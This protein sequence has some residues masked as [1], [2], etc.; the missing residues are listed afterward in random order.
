MVKKLI[1]SGCSFT[2]PDFI[3]DHH[4][5]LDTSW[6]KWPEILG[7]K[8]GMEVINLGRCGAG[9]EYIHASLMDKIST[10]DKSEIGLVIAAWSKSERRDW[11]DGLI[12]SRRSRLQHRGRWTNKRIDDLGDTHYFINR[13]FRY[14]YSLQ[15]FC[16]RFDI[17]FKHFQMIELYTAKETYLDSES[18]P[19]KNA[20][21]HKEKMRYNRVLKAHNDAIQKAQHTKDSL[22]TTMRM[23]PYFTKINNF[24]GWPLI[25]ELNGW[26]MQERTIGWDEEYRISDDDA[27][28][29]SDG[30]KLIADF[31]YENI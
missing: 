5:E 30:H 28:P 27:H 17:P 20:K 15:C 6:P 4:P 1:V 13:S 14:Y 31:I 26:T 8:L 12:K 19:W 3:S 29:N 11:Q 9:N 23:N 21:N 25:H 10:M 24:L 18:L 22:Q 7:E 16:E 2:D